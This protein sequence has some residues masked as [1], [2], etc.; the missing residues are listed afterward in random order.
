[1]ATRMAKAKAKPKAAKRAKAKSATVEAA[2]PA[3]A[4][5]QAAKPSEVRRVIDQ[6]SAMRLLKICRS[7]QSEANSL[8]GEL[9]EEIANAVAKKGLH[10]K[11]FSVIRQMDKMEPP[12]LADYIESLYHLIDV[13]GMAERANSA[14]SFTASMEQDDDD[15]E[16]QTIAESDNEA[17]EVE[18]DEGKVSEP[19]SIQPAVVDPQLSAAQQALRQVQGA[20]H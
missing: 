20:K 1:M 19:T 6:A 17:A 11:A 16:Q 2:A 15:G 3:P 4:P 18:S 10:K 13:C 12:Q 8:T 5:T 7:K 9:R 14:P